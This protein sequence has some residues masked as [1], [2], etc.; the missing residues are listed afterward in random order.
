MDDWIRLTAPALLSAELPE[1]TTILDPILATKS[2]ALL[3]GA[4]GLG[5]TFVAL[6][7]ARAVAAGESFLGWKS[8]RPHRVLYLDGEMAAADIR[9]RVAAFGPP[10][11]TLE[12]MLADLNRGPLLDLADPRSQTRLFGAWGNPELVVLDNLASL[13]GLTTGDPDRWS[14]LQRFLMELRRLGLAVLMIHH[15]NKKGLQRGSSRR[16]DMLDLVMAMRR[17]D[18]W[19]PA[20]GTRF[21]IHFEKARSL[22]GAAIEPIETRLEQRA[23]RLHWQWAAAGDDPRLV[24]LVALLERGMS[25]P[26]IG[27]QLGLSRSLAYKLR[28]RARRLGRLDLPCR[29]D[30][31]GGRGPGD[32]PPGARFLDH[33]G[34]PPVRGR[35]VRDRDQ[36]PRALCAEARDRGDRTM[37]RSTSQ[38]LAELEEDARPKPSPEEEPDFTGWTSKEIDDWRMAQVARMPGTDFVALARETNRSPPSREPP[39][40]PEL[41]AAWDARDAAILAERAARAAAAR[42]AERPGSAAAQINARTTREAADKAACAAEEAERLAEEAKR[43]PPPV[44]NPDAPGPGAAAEKPKPKPAPPPPP[45]TEPERKQW[46]EERA[47]WSKPSR[48]EEEDARR[49]RPLYQCLVEYDPIAWFQAEQEGEDYDPLE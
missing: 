20:D 49:G 7:I 1:R 39:T 15:A 19:N 46:W 29:G 33:A 35:D 34:I 8:P 22:H 45:A 26:Q 25:V 4:R 5:K 16:E 17:P 21:E 13:A 2:L 18:G 37:N 32:A 43:R 23:D 47:H 10:P 12:F 30:R 3:Y 14:E 6:G 24:R 11:P 28:D 44:E 41:Y 48:V 38:T 42:L 9:A 40:P 27:E 36:D 31:R